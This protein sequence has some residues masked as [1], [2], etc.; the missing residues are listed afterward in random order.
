MMIDNI[1]VETNEYRLKLLS[2]TWSG[3]VVIYI[4]NEQ[5]GEGGEK[6]K[7][8]VELIAGVSFTFC[9]LIVNDWDRYLTL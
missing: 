5:F 3:P 8:G 6:I 7:N 2:S 9:E 4:S 1:I